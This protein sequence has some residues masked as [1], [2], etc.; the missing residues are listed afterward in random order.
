MDR[1]CGRNLCACNLHSHV[2]AVGRGVFQAPCMDGNRVPHDLAC[3]RRANGGTLLG[4]VGVCA[5]SMQSSQVCTRLTLTGLRVPL[6]SN[7][8]R[9]QDLTGEPLWHLDRHEVWNLYSPSLDYVHPVKLSDPAAQQ[10]V[11]EV[12]LPEADAWTRNCGMGQFGGSVLPSH[13]ARP[14]NVVL[15][16]I[17]QYP[18]PVS[19]PDP[20][21][22]P[23]VR[24]VCTALVASKS[25]GTLWLAPVAGRV[26]CCDCGEGATFAPRVVLV[27]ECAVAPPACSNTPHRCMGF[28]THGVVT[29]HRAKGSCRR[30]V[31]VT[32]RWWSGGGEPCC[33]VTR[34]VGWVAVRTGNLRRRP[35]HPMW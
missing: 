7:V 16:W 25:P 1:V 13:D 31:Q 3:S 19:L 17:E 14:R 35:C 6:S 28:G 4:F 8:G 24:P 29:S 20:G 5:P 22:W 18:S 26:C 27:A 33:R 9:E 15:E 30:G 34:R 10:R 21:T 11:R 32:G 12:F 23:E 2:R